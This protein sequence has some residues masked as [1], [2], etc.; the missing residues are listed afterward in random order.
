[1]APNNRTGALKTRAF[2]GQPRAFRPLFACRSSLD[3]YL[4]NGK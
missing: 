1:M 4:P 3:I 2:Y